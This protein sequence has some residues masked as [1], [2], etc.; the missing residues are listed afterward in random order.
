MIVSEKKSP[1][2]T[3]DVKP[4]ELTQKSKC[5]RKLV[6]VSEKKKPDVADDGKPELPQKRKR[7]R[8]LVNVEEFDFPSRAAKNST[9]RILN[10]YT[11]LISSIKNGEQL[12][13]NHVNAANRLLQSQFSE[14]QGLA[15]PVLGQKLCFPNFDDILGYSGQAY[16]QVLHNGSD[17]WITIE[18]VSK[19][20]VHIYD[21]LFLKPN[22]CIIKQ[23]SSI[24]QSKSHQVQ[25]LLE[26]VQ[27]QRNA[28]DCGV[29]AIAFLTDLC[30]KIDP[31]ARH[32]PSSKKLREHLI[33]CFQEGM[34]TPFSSIDSSKQRPSVMN[35]NLYCSCRQPYA[36]EHVK[37]EHLPLNEDAQ[38]IQCYLCDRWYHRSCV[39][40]SEERIQ[41][42]S[43]SQE[44]WVCEFRGCNTVFHEMFDSD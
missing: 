23:I 19:E 9:T 34:M 38:M 35:V 29:Y 8:K 44:T 12:N 39:D 32:Y 31:S 7:T 36:L 14:L 16:M 25:L 17:H 22:Y 43:N 1:D 28:I 41:E 10:D 30:H 42:L 37:P 3:D 15:S 2:V 6:N 11:N 21:S 26:K 13:D 27:F 4:V 40:I 33:H 5:T 20:E 24:I 18:I